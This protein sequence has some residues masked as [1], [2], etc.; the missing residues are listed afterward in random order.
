MTT[1]TIRTRILALCGGLLAVTAII[2]G[3][4]IHR[5]GAGNDELAAIVHGSAVASRRSVELRVHIIRLA[6]SER[7]LLLADS[8]KLRKVASDGTDRIFLQ[9][10]E[11]RSDLRA[12]GDP[13][14]ASK[15]DQLDTVLREHDEVHKQV[16]A[17][18][19]KASVERAAVLFATEGARQ[20]DRVTVSLGA[21]DAALARHPRSRRRGGRP[22]HSPRR[23]ARQG[24]RRARGRR[25]Q[26]QRA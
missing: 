13:A 10:D 7:D 20:A 1:M 25:G 5:L 2:A 22:A 17:L 15:L 9:R 11:A 14:I 26:P 21:L 18:K 6:R 16:R 8:D 19:A 4:G 3:L 23:R 12:L 24:A